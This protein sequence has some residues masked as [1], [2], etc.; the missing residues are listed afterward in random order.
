MV[1]T[2]ESVV[3]ELRARTDGFDRKI[4]DSSRQFDRSMNTIGGASGR[5][6]GKVRRDMQRI[7][8]S[9]RRSSGQIQNTLR[10]LAAS[11]GAYF[12]TRE[13]G[14][15]V[16]SFTRLQNQL[17]VAGL[18]GEK[19][20]EVQ[21]ELRGI[22]AQYG[23]ELEALASVFNRAT[24][25][26][27]ELGAST[28]QII[29][30]NQ[31]VA[32]SLKVSGTS[33][34]EASG[35]LLQLSQALGS[36]VV[37]AEEFNSILEGALPLAQAAARGI[38]GY[39]GSVAAL[40]AAVVEGEIT[41][42]EFFEGILKGGT[43]T[44]EQAENATLTLAGAF[45]VLKNELTLYIGEAS[46][47]N[48]ITATLS[49]A[50]RSLAENL[51]RIIPAITAIIAL[52]GARYTGL[53]LAAT[54]ATIANA[55]ANAQAA[56]AANAL[57]LAQ[58]RMGPSFGPPTAAMIAQT[59]AAG[60]LAVAK[61]ILATGARGVLALFGGPVPAAV[62]AVGAAMIYAAQ[63]SESA[64]EK[65]DRLKKSADDAE[66]EAARMEATLRAAG[67]AIGEVEVAADEGA[68]AIDG[69]GDAAKR[70]EKDLYDL[71]QQAIRTA[72]ALVT[73]QL[74][75]NSARRIEI[76]REERD[77][78]RRRSS[79]ELSQTNAGAARIAEFDRNESARDAE[80]AE[81]DREFKALNRQRNAIITSVREGIDL[82][83]APPIPTNTPDKD[84]GKK[85]TGP[86]QAEIDFRF[87]GESIQLEQDALSAL[88]RFATNANER[89]DLEIA[90]INLAQQR[91]NAEI[92]ADAD[93][94]DTQ[95]EILQAQ[96]ARVANLDRSAVELER[97]AQLERERLDF[98]EQVND[99]EV[100]NARFALE[101]ARTSGQRKEAALRILDLQLQLEK[102]LLE[103]VLASETASD[104]D[105]AR[106]ALAL[107]QLE[108]RRAQET[109][110]IEQDNL[111][112]IGSFLDSIP[113]G[114]EEINEAL[115]MVAANGLKGV[116][117]GLTDAIVN[118]RSLR[119]VAFAVLQG[120]TTQLVR[121]ALQQI[122]L[123]VVGQTAGNA[124]I[125]ATGAQAAAAAAAWAP[126]AALASLATLGSNA[127]PAAV[128]LGST[129][130]LAQALAATSS[131]GGLRDGGEVIGP[132][133]PRDDKV[134][135][136][137]SN[138]EFVINA[139]S[140]R[141]IGLNR[142][143][144]MNRTG[145]IPGFRDGG[146]ISLQSPGNGQATSG[147]N[148]LASIDDQS[149]SRLAA[150]VARAA[151]SM[152]NVNLYPTLDPAKALEAGLNSPGGQRAFFEFLS[153]NSE[154]FGQAAS[155]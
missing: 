86:T 10:G 90:S 148:G 52:I 30:L 117:D 55:A 46:R 56:A 87:E 152:P 26:Q 51:D 27:N 70:T 130:A 127:G 154:R 13:L 136:R 138:R 29:R 83:G 95:K 41:S 103:S 149:L 15:L 59:A 22:G 104:A 71:E 14:A 63:N 112:P 137:L 58:I 68:D 33:T 100:Q 9:V 64:A 155:Q 120:I 8:G 62:L 38:D 132:G 61:G 25:A 45:T 34:Q 12:S 150:V 24:L 6:E 69:V 75:A 43:Q 144:F 151:E 31:I 145:E 121:L 118:F 114:I 91:A 17:R 147:K 93:Y 84:K 19:L 7:E 79:P 139:E 37:R 109:F 66:A 77:I 2:A 1:Q 89:A 102:A 73:E 106:A 143:N 125:A 48:G 135:R 107:A 128:A 28:E 113:A 110:N 98:L 20:A 101:N 88:Q 18:E 133:G 32:A 142:L 134:L 108:Q 141:K 5:A 3:V 39:S 23:V 96:V 67:V 85:K 21:E 153:N 111:G 16:D 94:S 122:I 82:N 129:T 50:I 126:A 54:G 146:T 140:S 81:L 115:E 60:R 92:Q 119:E 116:V 11:L 57:T 65:M 4:K 99:G 76:D 49:D 42:R 131:V 53:L 36:G 44:I 80:I 47:S 123:K 78:D 105:K 74:Q 124:A 40:R 72:L 97:Q 35:A